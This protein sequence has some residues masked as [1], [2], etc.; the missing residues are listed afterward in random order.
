ML[1]F[2]LDSTDINYKIL[3]FE[4]WMDES[5]S[6]IY[7]L[8]DIHPEQFIDKVRSFKQETATVYNQFES[9]FFFNYVK[10]SVGLSVDNFNIIGGPSKQDKFDFYLNEDSIYY[11]IQSTSNTPNCSTRNTC[12]SWTRRPKRWQ[13]KR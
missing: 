11:K 7:Q 9:P 2:R 12:I 13:K 3:G 5:I 8:K 4:A 6:E 1:F 10:Y